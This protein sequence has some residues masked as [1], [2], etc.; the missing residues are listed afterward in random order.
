MDNLWLKRLSNLILINKYCF[1]NGIIDSKKKKKRVHFD[2]VK[3]NF[4]D[5]YCLCYLS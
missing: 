3:D 2:K 4:F 5:C 1:M